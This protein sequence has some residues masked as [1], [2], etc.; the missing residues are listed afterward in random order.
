VIV[1]PIQ[2]TVH[3]ISTIIL[4]VFLIHDVNSVIRKGTLISM[5]GKKEVDDYIKELNIHMNCSV[6]NALQVNDERGMG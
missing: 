4:T 5:P 3:V 6:L 1:D 2:Y